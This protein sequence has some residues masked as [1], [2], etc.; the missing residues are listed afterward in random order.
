MLTLPSVPGRQ[1][2]L[3]ET[4]C[5][6]F[7]SFDCICYGRILTERESHGSSTLSGLG[8]LD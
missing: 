3:F 2:V 5:F 1:L 4:V 6:T 7:V 8:F